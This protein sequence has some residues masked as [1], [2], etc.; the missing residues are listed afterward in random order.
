MLALELSHLR[1]TVVVAVLLVIKVFFVLAARWVMRGCSF[2]C[3]KC[4]EMRSNIAKLVITLV[5]LIAFSVFMI[6]ITLQGA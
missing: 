2:S 6:R 5:I 3:Q 4:P 1:M